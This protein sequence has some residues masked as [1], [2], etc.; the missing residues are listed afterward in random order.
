MAQ[1]QEK[2]KEN[3]LSI[4]KGCDED[5]EVSEYEIIIQSANLSWRN[6]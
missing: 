2:K 1:I 4:R 6:S 3:K 5:Q